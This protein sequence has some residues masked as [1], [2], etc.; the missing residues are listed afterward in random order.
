MTGSRLPKEERSRSA[1]WRA[2]VVKWCVPQVLV[3]RSKSLTA[4]LQVTAGH[5]HDASS[6]QQE[7]IGRLASIESALPVS[8][9]RPKT[10]STW[11]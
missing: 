10:R 2:L 9:E 3:D 5:A 6:W 11:Y 7:V 4:K 8:Q 1:V